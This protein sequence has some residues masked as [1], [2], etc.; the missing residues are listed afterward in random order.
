VEEEGWPSGQ[1]GNWMSEGLW[2]SI[3]SVT[4]IV[5]VSLGRDRQWVEDVNCIPGS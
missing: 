1:T 2:V 5:D 3:T 4:G